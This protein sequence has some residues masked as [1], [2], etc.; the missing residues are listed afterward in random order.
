MFCLLEKA[1]Y[2][3]TTRR[4]SSYQ[5]WQHNW[6][7]LSFQC[8]CS[9]E[10]HQN[11]TSTAAK[12]TNYSL[13]PWRFFLRMLKLMLNSQSALMP[14]WYDCIATYL[15]VLKCIEESG[16]LVLIFS[17]DIND[18]FTEQ[19]LKISYRIDSFPDIFEILMQESTSI[20]KDISEV[21]L[22]LATELL[23][24]FWAWPL[25]YHFGYD[26]IENYLLI[27][28]WLVHEIFL[29]HS[30]ATYHIVLL[31]HCLSVFIFCQLSSQV[32]R[33]I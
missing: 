17:I 15:L 16:T 10:D 19:K 6:R 8:W 18:V 14:H 22:V 28:L 4:P 30:T 26:V 23:K 31:L 32:I 33:Y 1:S 29:Q 24:T 20:R 11:H 21:D 12:S 7:L 5:E 25:N 27:L 2:S 13:L 9:E 3:S